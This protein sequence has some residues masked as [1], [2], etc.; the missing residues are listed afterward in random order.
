MQ[1]IDDIISDACDSTLPISVVLRRCLVLAFDLDNIT[2]RDWVENELNGYDSNTE[3]P[4]YRLYKIVSKGVFLVPYQGQLSDQPLAPGVLSEEHRHWAEQAFL[5]QPIIAYELPKDDV[6]GTVH[7]AWPP[8]LTVH[9]QT[10]FFEG[11]VLNRAW[12]EIPKS[13]FIGLVDIV[14]NRV[15]R[16]ALEIRKELGLVGGSADNLESTKIEQIVQ[17]QIIG[18]QHNYYNTVNVDTATNSPIQ[19]GSEHSNQR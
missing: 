6:H 15:L 9:Y 1:L 7:I 13:L 12:Q 17:S 3:L 10:A 2:L 19:Q 5:D 11:L 8:D 4:E 14:R 18:E 16:F